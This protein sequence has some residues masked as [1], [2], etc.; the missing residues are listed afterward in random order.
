MGWWTRLA[1]AI[2]A[3]GAILVVATI[4]AV[5]VAGAPTNC[6]DAVAVSRRL[7]QDRDDSC[8]TRMYL[9]FRG[10]S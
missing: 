7:G 8:A 6:G 1:L 10:A 2:L 5:G 4:V 9:R 3:A